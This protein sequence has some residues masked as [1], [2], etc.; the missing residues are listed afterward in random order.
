MPK[1]KYI[2][3]TTRNVIAYSSMDGKL[4]F[5]IRPMGENGDVQ[6]IPG[7]Q[8]EDPRLVK[9]LKYGDVVWSKDGDE[10]DAAQIAENKAKDAE[11]LSSV[12]ANLDDSYKESFV[13]R[14]CC[15]VTA[16]GSQCKRK[17]PTKVGIAELN[18][19]PVFCGIHKDS[20]A[21]DFIKND[22]G[23]WVPKP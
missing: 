8:H 13:E 10:I 19:A 1:G 22:D 23:S 2:Q 3:N 17:V 18:A 12:M 20:K 6:Y 15:A 5:I 21:E 11:R 16:A 9:L 4:H 7:E 14:Q